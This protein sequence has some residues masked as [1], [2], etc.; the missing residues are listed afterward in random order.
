MFI[1]IKIRRPF[2]DKFASAIIDTSSVKL[3]YVVEY[4]SFNNSYVM[5]TTVG[6]FTI[7]ET[8]Y[9]LLYKTLYGEDYSNDT[10]SN[11]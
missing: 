11:Q 10:R 9:Y 5:E 8:S 1:K 3:L 6:G 4:E 2:S 7:D